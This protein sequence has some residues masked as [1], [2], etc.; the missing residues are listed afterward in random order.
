M[1]P[2]LSC[3]KKLKSTWIKNL[4]VKPDTQKLIEKKMGRASNI[5]SKERNS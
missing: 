4:H 5:S 2:F 3:C 1:D